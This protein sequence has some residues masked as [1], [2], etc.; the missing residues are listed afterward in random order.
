MREHALVFATR[1]WP[2]LPLS[3]GTKV[4][5]TTRGLYDATV[6]VE[7]I[8]AMWGDE[9]DCNVGLRTG[10]CFDVLDIDGEEG[11]EEL[12]RHV[13]LDFQFPGP[14]VWTPKGVHCYFQPTGL[15][16]RARFVPGC[17]WR[18]VGGYVVA[19]PSHLDT[20]TYTWWRDEPRYD[21]LQ[22]VPDWLLELLERD[23]HGGDTPCAD[24]HPFARFRQT[25]GTSYALTALENEARAV[26]SAADG[27]RNDV[28]NRAAFAVGRF[29]ADGTLHADTIE[30]VLLTGALTAGL[31]EHEAVRT[32]RSGLQGRQ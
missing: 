16:N 32:I 12:A 23:A 8:E 25:G 17:D 7:T 24:P 31:S 15:G 1:G 20:T 3:P 11:W 4:P 14:V 26:A 18:G 10:T 2:T 28:L 22:P 30:R 29:V 27:T 13:A 6:D 19:P 5:A 21:Q 9:P